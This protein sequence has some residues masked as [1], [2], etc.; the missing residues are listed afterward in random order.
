MHPCT[1]ASNKHCERWVTFF[2]SRFLKKI[3]FDLADLVPILQ[4]FVTRYSSGE[5]A[6]HSQPA[7][8]DTVDDDLR[9]VGQG[10]A[11]IVACD[12]RKT[13]TGDIDFLI[14]RQIHSW[15][16][17]DYTSICGKSI[18]VHIIIVIIS[19]AFGE[20]NSEA[21]QAIT[22]MTTIALFYLLRPNTYTV[23]TTDDASLSLIIM[24]TTSMRTRRR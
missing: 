19:L 23:T 22:D 21:S 3:L 18:P 1:H 4:V 8:V 5:I 14:Q 16:Q 12:I 20:H 10:F 17:Q 9:V 15:E 11:H 24:S 13:E 7:R 2:H 6:P